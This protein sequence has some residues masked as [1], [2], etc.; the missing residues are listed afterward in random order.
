MEE[1]K[2]VKEEYL[3]KVVDQIDLSKQTPHNDPNCQHLDMYA[4]DEEDIPGTVTYKC[5]HCPYGKIV[6]TP[7]A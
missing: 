2:S 6:R 7:I 4:E 5:R 1:A 3:G